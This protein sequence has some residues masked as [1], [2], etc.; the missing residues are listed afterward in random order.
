M[1]FRSEFRPERARAQKLRKERKCV[2]DRC[3]DAERRVD[4]SGFGGDELPD[5]SRSRSAAREI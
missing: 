4:V 1:H 5:M 3:H 2:R